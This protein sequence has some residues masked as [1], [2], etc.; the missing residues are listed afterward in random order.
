MQKKSGIFGRNGV[1]SRSATARFAMARNPVEPG[2]QGL[3]QGRFF[4]V[5]GR[6]S[7]T[8]RRENV[9]KWNF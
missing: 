6:F 8:L 3:F 5:K 4:A 1:L 7:I 9:Q 2:L